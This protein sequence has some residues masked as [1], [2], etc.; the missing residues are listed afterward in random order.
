MDLSPAGACL[1]ICGIIP[2]G[3]HLKFTLSFGRNHTV[4]FH[5]RVVYAR[6]EARTY[7]RRYGVAFVRLDQEAV[8]GLSAYLAMR[9]RQQRNGSY[10]I[11][12]E[13]VKP[14]SRLSLQPMQ[15]SA[16]AGYR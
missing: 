14:F 5:G 15:G 3:E 16:P 2:I 7:H 1:R 4:E 10:W 11:S 6:E 12:E 13:P 9:R 8:E